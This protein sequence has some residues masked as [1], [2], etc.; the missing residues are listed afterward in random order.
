MAKEITLKLKPK[1]ADALE[2]Y[3][4]RVTQEDVVDVCGNM[5][6]AEISEICSLLFR[7][8]LAL[9]LLRRK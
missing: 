2:R 3:L 5:P 4:A 9:Q 7:L 8:R 1:E 6:A